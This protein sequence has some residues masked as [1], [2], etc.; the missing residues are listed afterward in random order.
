[1]SPDSASSFSVASVEK[2]CGDDSTGAGECWKADTEI[3]ESRSS[4]WELFMGESCL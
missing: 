2:V 1:M 4:G 3:R